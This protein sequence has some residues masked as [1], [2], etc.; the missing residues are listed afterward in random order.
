VP[1]YAVYARRV[2]GI[3][4]AMIGTYMSASML[5]R[6][7]SNLFWAPL[8]DRRGA[9]VPL[10]LATVLA[11]LVPLLALVL[12]LAPLPREVVMWW[13]SAVFLLA[14]AAAAGGFIGATN[15]FV[16]TSPE[17]ER[18]LY[19]GVLNSF[20][21]ATTVLPMIGGV[22]IDHSNFQ[23]V[24]AISAAAAVAAALL[25]RGLAPTRREAPAQ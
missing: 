14:G 15:Y 23:V 18:P 2:V 16:E 20:G 12:A 24:F 8:S 9:L 7:G 11:C 25:T 22:I 21:A 5:G 19:L 17:L 3:P 13:F 6:I 4:E 10:R 1:F